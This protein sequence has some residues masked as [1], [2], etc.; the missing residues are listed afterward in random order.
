MYWAYINLGIA[1]IAIRGALNH[2]LVSIAVVFSF[3]IISVCIFF[4]VELPGMLWFAFGAMLYSLPCIAAFSSPYTPKRAFMALC[5]A[6][7]MLL[8][9]LAAY[10]WVIDYYAIV[11]SFYRPV[12]LVLYLLMAVACLWG[13]NG[14]L[15]KRNG[16]YNS[17]HGIYMGIRQIA[18]MVFKK[19]A[20]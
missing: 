9:L 5:C 1:A 11:G 4:E 20:G 18:H 12:A 8:E 16:S 14:Q 13:S 15:W 17:W 10:L 7:L 19:G 3:F 2:C 6:L